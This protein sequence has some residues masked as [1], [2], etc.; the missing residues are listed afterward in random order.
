MSKVNINIV[1]PGR[2]NS[3][4]SSVISPNLIFDTE[5]NYRSE[6]DED[7]SSNHIIEETINLQY[8]P[9]K[10]NDFSQ[11]MIKLIVDSHMLP[12]D[13]KPLNPNSNCTVIYGGYALMNQI[14]E[15]NVDSIEIKQYDNMILLLRIISKHNIRSIY[16]V[17]N[18][19]SSDE[20]LPRSEISK[21]SNIIS[22]RF[23]NNS[24]FKEYLTK[25]S[26]IYLTINWY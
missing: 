25:G 19:T 15:C 7:N 26:I 22:S 9:R 11:I 16:C 17:L 2:S 4:L 24:D 8:T 12:M 18:N 14:G 20:L 13:F 21:E 10:H 1:K 6:S 5:E 3:L 23:D